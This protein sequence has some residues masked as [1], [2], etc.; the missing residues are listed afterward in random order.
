MYPLQ[1]GWCHTSTDQLLSANLFGSLCYQSLQYCPTVLVGTV[2]CWNHSAA[3]LLP[4]WLAHF[5]WHPCAIALVSIA[6]DNGPSKDDYDD[7]PI[8]KDNVHGYVQLPQGKFECLSCIFCLDPSADMVSCRVLHRTTADP[9]Q[10]LWDTWPSAQPTWA[11]P[12][13]QTPAVTVTEVSSLWFSPHFIGVASWGRSW[14]QPVISC[15]DTRWYKYDKYG[16]WS[17][18]VAGNNM[19]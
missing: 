12:Y 14:G 5:H 15:R 10:M 16:V 4:L 7:L 13:R 17:C 3:E 19:K 6:V 9:P 8:T 11:Q 2:Y 1:V 18:F